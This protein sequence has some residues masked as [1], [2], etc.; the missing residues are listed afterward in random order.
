MALASLRSEKNNSK[1]RITQQK[2]CMV[3]SEFMHH[4]R[5]YLPRHEWQAKQEWQ[6]AFDQHCAKL[7]IEAAPIGLIYKP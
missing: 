2:N 4:F 7:P 6:Q 1:T 3:G 5:V